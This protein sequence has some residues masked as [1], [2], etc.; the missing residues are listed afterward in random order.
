MF[1]TCTRVRIQTGSMKVVDRGTLSLPHRVH[2]LPMCCRGSCEKDDP[3]KEASMKKGFKEKLI[4]KVNQDEDTV[5][6]VH[7]LCHN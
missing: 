4:A 2:P 3:K 5:L 7:T 1:Y 6:V